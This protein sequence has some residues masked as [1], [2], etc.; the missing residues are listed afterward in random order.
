[1]AAKKND[2][3][4]ALVAVVD[5]LEPLNDGDRQWVLQSA[6]SKFS[7][8]IQL[9]ASAN[10][11][12]GNQPAAGAGPS[13]V[14]TARPNANTD[15]KTFVK[16]KDPNSE[17]QRVACLAYYLANFRDTHA[18]KTLDISKLN[19]EAKG[20]TFNVARAVNNAANAKHKYFSPVGKGQKQITSHG[21]EIVEALPDL[22]KVK[23]VEARKS[24]K[25]GRPKK[26]SKK[27]A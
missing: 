1:M 7:V 26:K 2:S 25:R 15:V 22:E 21:D 24:T 16:D 8:A 10:V 4:S 14:G 20:P 27:S 11:S 12:A 9:A 23:E 17:T 18:F 6:A 13:A 3:T 19:T 5:A